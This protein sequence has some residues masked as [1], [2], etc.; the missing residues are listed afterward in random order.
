MDRMRA[1]MYD[2]KGQ[3]KRERRRPSLSERDINH[4]G[5]PLSPYSSDH[6]FLRI[7]LRRSFFNLDSRLASLPVEI[8]CL[9]CLLQLS[10]FFCVEDVRRQ[11]SLQIELVSRSEEQV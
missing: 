3:W 5:F 1:R 10:Q 2:E 6:S 8:S 11:K 7:N 9:P 4:S